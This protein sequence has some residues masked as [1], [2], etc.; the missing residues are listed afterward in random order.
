MCIRDRYIIAN[1]AKWEEM[2]DMSLNLEAGKILGVGEADLLNVLERISR[3]DA[4]ALMQDN[5]IPFTISENVQKVFEENAAQLGLGD[6]YKEASQAI[7]SLQQ[8]MEDIT[9]SANEWPDLTDL[10]SFAPMTQG[11]PLQGLGQG[12]GGAGGA[13]L[14]PSIYQ[15]PSLTLNQGN[16]AAMPGQ[17]NLTAAQIALLSPS[18]QA[19]YMQRNRNRI[20]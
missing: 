8:I 19:Y 20:T 9:L 1:K 6:P 4:M 7:E 17:N 16:R 11:I 14:N 2:K 3:K 10:F 12:G 18:E 13:T 5:F 15:R